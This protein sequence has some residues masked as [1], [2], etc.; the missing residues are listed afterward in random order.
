LEIIHWYFTIRK[1]LIIH[2]STAERGECALWEPPGGADPATF[3]LVPLL[4]ASG[5]QF[6]PDDLVATHASLPPGTYATVTNTR[7]GQFVRVR[8]VGQSMT[9]IIGRPMEL[10]NGAF[11][12]VAHPSE[13]VFP[14]RISTQ[15]PGAGS[16]I[17]PGQGTGGFVPPSS[18][19]GYDRPPNS[20]LG[21]NRPQSSYFGYNRPQNPDLGYNRPQNPDLGYNH[22]PGSSIGYNQSPD[23]DYIQF[24]GQGHSNQQSGYGYNQ[25]QISGYPQQHGYGYQARPQEGYISPQQQGYPNLQPDQY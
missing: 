9:P 24:P 25:P 20:D 2:V 6:Q 19:L 21:Y 14:C 23:T 15:L 13:A 7:T 22:P 4:T 16:S 11:N 12:Q 18:G 17:R 3:N 10:S 8:V 1:K 5:D